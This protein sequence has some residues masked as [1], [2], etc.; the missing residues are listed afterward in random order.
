MQFCPRR[1]Y[2]SRPCHGSASSFFHAR[3]PVSPSSNRST[4]SDPANYT[5]VPP[6]DYTW[7]LG[8]C[9]VQFPPPSNLCFSSVSLDWWIRR[10]GS[11]YNNC[12]CSFRSTYRSCSAT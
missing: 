10:G 2:N 5:P 3:S 7:A 4:I 6:A 12:F 8:T 9:F 1:A 11:V